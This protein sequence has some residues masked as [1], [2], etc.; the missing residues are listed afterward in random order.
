MKKAFTTAILQKHTSTIEIPGS[1]S[2]YPSLT[3]CLG[4][5]EL[6][7]LLD[8]ASNLNPPTLLTVFRLYCGERLSVSQ[9]ARRCR[10]SVGTISSRLPASCVGT[11]GSNSWMKS[12][13]RE[14]W[15]L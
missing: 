3:T 2:Q 15:R 10:C 4:A 8:S 6:L 7:N 5:L 11:P 13:K 12:R 9:V 1:A 14:S